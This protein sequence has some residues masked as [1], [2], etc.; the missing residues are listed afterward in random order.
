[1]AYKQI[2]PKIVAEGGT[3]AVTLTDFGV[4]VGSGTTAITPLAVGTT[5]ELLIGTS[6]ADPAF[7]SSAA[8]DFT[9]TTASAGTTRA[10][11]VS[12][13]DATAA[14]YSSAQLDLIAQSASTGDP[15]VHFNVNTGQDYALGVD[16]SDSDALKINDDTD[17]STGNNLW[18]MTS[19]GERI[20]PLQPAF[21]AYLPS[22]DLNET[23]DGTIYTLGD[24]DVGTALTEEFD[25]GGNFTP[26]ASGGALFT[27]PVDGIYVFIINFYLYGIT[28]SHTS[29]IGAFAG[30][31]ITTHRF[32]Q[33]DP[34]NVSASGGFMVVGGTTI[35]QMSA[36]DTLQGTIQLSGSTK[37]VEIGGIQGLTY[38]QGYLLG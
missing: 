36:S 6:A 22:D 32:A 8:A 15:F 20:L 5:G 26:G 29:T 4:L 19:S 14:N 21:S 24:T 9:F 13:T 23:G 1:M 3:G 35:Y 11:T 28:G 2:S 10:L 12:N 7:G 38:L 33:N 18:K 31:G 16:N 34:G 30:S 37:V 17:P 27:A 25:I